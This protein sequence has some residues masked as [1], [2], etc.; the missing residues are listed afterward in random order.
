MDRWSLLARAWYR[1]PSWA[2]G[3]PTLS[4][5]QGEA[6]A[7]HLGGSGPVWRRSS[8]S[9]LTGQE[10]KGSWSM[11]PSQGPGPG[12]ELG[13]GPWRASGPSDQGLPRSRLQPRGARLL[14]GMFIGNPEIKHFIYKGL[15]SGSCIFIQI[16]KSKYR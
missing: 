15:I 2:R 11:Q 13:T 12:P 7:A 16:I 10:L 5:G 8:L 6:R 4:W 1:L 14:S 3:L 9:S